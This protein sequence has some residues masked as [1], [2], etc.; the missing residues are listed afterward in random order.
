MTVENYDE[1][2]H[3]PLD[4]ELQEQILQEQ[5]ECSFVWGPKDHW[6][7]G[8]IMSYVWRD[9]KF[10]LTATSQRARIQAIRRD[11]RVSLIIS[12]VGTRLGPA[13]S[14]T[15]KG[16]VR[17]HDDEAT[18]ARVLPQIAAVVLPGADELQEKFVKMMESD[19][20]LVLEVTPEKWITFD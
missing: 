18:K 7:V 1:V 19:R 12:S 16:R 8:V 9:G 17:I 14:I 20:R 3:Y 11:P 13:K 15:V 2:Q 4:P 6:A 10:W 5:N